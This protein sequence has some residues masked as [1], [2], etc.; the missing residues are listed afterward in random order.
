[1]RKGLLG[2][3]AALA[4]GAG[5]AWGQE[6]MPMPPAGVAPAPVLPGAGT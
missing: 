1:M 4:A 2:S 6:P 3:I 5:T